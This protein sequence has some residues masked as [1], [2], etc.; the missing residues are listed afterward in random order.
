[1]LF[2]FFFISIISY[3]LYS[4]YRRFI[5]PSK[6]GAVGASPFSRYTKRKRPTG[7]AVEADFEELDDD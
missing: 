2:R 3:L 5:R 4:L 1:M 6:G 7:D